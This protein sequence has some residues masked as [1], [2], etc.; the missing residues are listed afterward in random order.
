MSQWSGTGVMVDAAVG[1]VVLAKMEEMDVVVAGGKAKLV[2]QLVNRREVEKM[3][4]ME[5]IVV[6]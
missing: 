6:D 4:L 2:P 5:D 1:I 3:N